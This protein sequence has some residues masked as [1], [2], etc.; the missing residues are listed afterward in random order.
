MTKIE[1]YIYSFIKKNLGLFIVIAV[2]FIRLGICFYLRRYD[3]MAQF[4]GAEVSTI[5][6]IVY[7]A[8]WLCF[9]WMVFIYTVKETDNNECDTNMISQQAK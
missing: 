1:Q 5:H 4:G 7:L 9:T 3:I 6:A 2:T 8:A